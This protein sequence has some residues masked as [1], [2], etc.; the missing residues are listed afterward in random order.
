VWVAFA[1]FTVNR[2]SPRRWHT[3]CRY[4][5]YNYGGLTRDVSLVTVPTAFIDDYDVHLAHG[6]TWQPGNT[7][8]SGYVHVLDAP[9]GTSVTVDIP[10]AGAKTTVMTGADGNA[11]FS[12]KAAS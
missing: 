9:A 11:P 6:P 10:E 5:W 7:E 2:H 3:L 1:S 8:I 4:D 12:V